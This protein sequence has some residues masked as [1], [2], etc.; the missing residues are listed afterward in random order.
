M[1]IAFFNGRKKAWGLTAA[2]KPQDGLYV[3]GVVHTLDE[4]GA[5]YCYVKFKW[6]LATDM[7]KA[8][9]RGVGPHEPA[10][11]MA[12]RMSEEVWYIF[13]CYLSG[14]RRVVWIEDGKPSWVRSIKRKEYES[15]I[16]VIEEG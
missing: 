1:S 12:L 11:L 5:G 15:D 4:E 10:H 8:M 9:P 3:S 6:P 13:C 16:C 7:G 2:T 14:G